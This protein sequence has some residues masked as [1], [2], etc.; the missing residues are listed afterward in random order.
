MMRLSPQRP[1]TAT[2]GKGI[3]DAL[4]CLLVLL[5]LL[6]SPDVSQLTVGL[7]VSVPLE[8]LLGVAVLLLCPVRARP[9][10]ATLFGVALGLLALM[11]LLDVGFL[12]IL[13]RPFDPGLDWSLLEDGMTCSL[14]PNV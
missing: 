7:F 6:A 5:T 12:G 1:V 11:K 3:A 4:A 13:G 9:A 10:I 8:A 14:R 2:L